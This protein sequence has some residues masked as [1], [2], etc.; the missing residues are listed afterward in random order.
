MTTV[1][2]YKVDSQCMN[3]VPFKAEIVAQNPVEGA[4]AK[5]LENQDSADFDLAGYRVSVENG[6][7]TVDLRLSPGSQRTFQ[8]LSI[9]EQLALFGGIRKT[10]V[11]NSGW[12]IT[13]VQFTQRGQEIVL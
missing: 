6:V 8:S 4:I 3:L 11:E 1:V 10:L 12:G 5:V 13:S 9:C 2:L 7:A